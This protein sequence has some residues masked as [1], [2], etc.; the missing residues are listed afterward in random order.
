MTM[1]RAF[2]RTEQVSIPNGDAVAALAQILI[3]MNGP[4]SR[5]LGSDNRNPAEGE[6]ETLGYSIEANAILDQ[7][8]ASGFIVSRNPKEATLG[9]K[10]RNTAAARFTAL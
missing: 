5:E 2:S 10:V 9:P 3:D 6:V 7:L 8:A 4:K 1:R